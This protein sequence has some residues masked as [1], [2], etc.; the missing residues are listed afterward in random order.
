MLVIFLVL[1]TLALPAFLYGTFYVARAILR[2]IRTIAWRET[3]GVILFS[4]VARF[5]RGKDVVKEALQ[6][7][8]SYM[9]DGVVREGT[10]VAFK[11]FTW[12][13]GNLKSLAAKY[14]QGQEVAVYYDSLHPENA[15]LEKGTA[16][17]DGLLLGALAL[18]DAGILWVWIPLP[19]VLILLGIAL[20]V[21]LVFLFR[22]LKQ[23]SVQTF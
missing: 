16:R 21:F 5:Y 14:S 15:V 17:A 11:S 13:F 19:S 23:S 20:I 18:I 7:S 6:L 3:S 10:R 12:F 8:Y 4:N 22:E 1:L 9:V 2:G